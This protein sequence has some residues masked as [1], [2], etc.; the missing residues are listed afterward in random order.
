MENNI[1]LITQA[2]TGSSRL[3]KKVLKKINGKTLLEIHLERLK[4]SKLISEIILATT[5]N[6][7]D[8]II[9]EIGR[10]L[11]ISC[12]CGSEND[13]LDR[14]YQSVKNKKP[15]WIVRVTSDCPLIDP[16]LID[17]IIKFTITKNIDYC[18]NILI[19]NYPDGQD[20]EIMSFNSLEIAWKEALLNSER[21]HVTP[22][23]KKNSSFNGGSLF[24]SE[25]YNLK[26]NYNNIRMTVDEQVDFDILKF[27]IDSLGI[28]KKWEVYTK[29][30]IDNNL[31]N[32][33]ITRN[34]GYIN[35]IKND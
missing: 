22:Y 31:V 19:E 13:V 10:K 34:E 6:K 30:M 7:E 16:F 26:K 35:S 28:D 27:V 11:S 29:F 33:N 5:K 1:I 15:N 32:S 18:S 4:K 24:S 25:N 3:P 14:F 20:I 12:F 8:K 9:C 17:E 23:I 21:E 2:R